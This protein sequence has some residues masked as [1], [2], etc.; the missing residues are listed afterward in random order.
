MSI[1]YLEG[2]VVVPAKQANLTKPEIVALASMG[3]ITRTVRDRVVLFVADNP[4]PF[5]LE[6]GK[7]EKVYLVEV[8]PRTELYSKF[9]YIA[10]KVRDTMNEPEYFL[11]KWDYFST[12]ESLVGL[13]FF[14]P[15]TRYQEGTTLYMDVPSL[16]K[17]E[18]TG[19]KLLTS[20]KFEPTPELEPLVSW[21][22]GHYKKMRDK[23]RLHDGWF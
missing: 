6:K 14:A 3:Y 11:C 19:T 13:G 9:F 10:T 23:A 15:G 16:I 21:S 1:K 22:L 20:I 8:P 4:G 7:I 2:T 12:V 18:R 5:L 17:Y